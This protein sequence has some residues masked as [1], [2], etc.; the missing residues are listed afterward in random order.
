MNGLKLSMLLID[1][2]KDNELK[3]WETALKYWGFFCSYT[4]MK[5]VQLLAVV[6]NDM[7]NVTINKL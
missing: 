7:Y 5:I 2:W 1:S 4:F 6:L 3:K